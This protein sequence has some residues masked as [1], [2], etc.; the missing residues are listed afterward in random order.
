[1]KKLMPVV[2][3]LLIVIILSSCESI[4][5]ENGK[6]PISQVPFTEVRMTDNFWAPKIEINKEVTIPIAF[7]YCEST[8]RVKNFEIAG[9]LAEGDRFLTTYP[10]DDS[11]VY[12]IIEGAAFTLHTVPDPELEA[13]VDSLIYKIG[14]AQEDDG[15]LYTNRTINGEEHVHP[16]GKGG[17]WVGTHDL[18]HELYNMGHLYEAAVAYYQATGKRELLDIAIKSAD[19]IYKDFGWDDVDK[20]INYPGHQVIEMGLVKLYQVTGDRKYL[21]LAK[22]F[23]DVRGDGPEYCQ[24]HMPVI[25]QT[26]AVGHSVRATYMYSGM[27]DVAALYNDDSYIK[28]I[29]NIWEDIVYKKLYVTGGIGAS[30]GNEGFG[31]AYHLPNMTAYCETCASIGNIFTNYRLFLQHGDSKYYD[32]LE[33]TLYNAMLSGVALS[34]DHFFYPN[35]LESFGQHERSEWFGCACCP[36]NISRFIPAVPGYIYA[37]DKNSVYVN[38]FAGNEAEFSFGDNMLEISQ[39]TNFPWDGKVEITVKPERDQK[40]SLK[41]RI[42]GWAEN[43]ALPGDLYTFSKESDHKASLFLNGEKLDAEISNGYA[44]IN[45]KW[46]A[47]DLIRLELPMEIRKLVADAR[48]EADLGRVAIQRGP[49]VYCAEWADNPDG[50]TRNLIL[51]ADAEMTSEFI[52]GILNGTNIIHARGRQS[53]LNINGEV[54]FGDLQDIKLIPYH[55]WA[56]RGRGEMLVWLPVEEEAV[57]PL[58]APTIA[59]RSKISG[60]T[61]TRTIES[62]ADQYEPLN[63]NDHTNPY[64]HWWPAR[65]RWEYLQYDFEKP[66]TISSSSVYWFDDGPQGGCRIP[67]EWELQ[68]RLKGEWVTVKTE[69]VYPVTR[70]GWDAVSFDPVMTDGVRLR[71]LLQKEF[72]SGVHEWV[73]E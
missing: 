5:K 7:G 28:A 66:E 68:Y 67:A 48:V 65:D 25:E 55:L 33:R 1:M 29:S 51:D 8:G 54:E 21:E 34:G 61:I 18:S 40:F 3:S 15:Y 56:N 26:E 30:G 38:L 11:D 20:Y 2:L 4:N 62:I 13:Y 24:A 23:L 53:M 59:F 6:Y 35:P 32:V 37:K 22:F 19:L 72:S 31:E 46:T 12:K 27:A 36:S 44:V 14:M 9:G 39:V 43:I 63:S 52:P 42:P 47:G 45:R 69:T 71:V 70:D 17:R 73:I 60:S 58:P 50:R 16:W 49:L 57:I 41:I 64:Y 10:F